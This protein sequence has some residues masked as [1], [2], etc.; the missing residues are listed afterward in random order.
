MSN[1]I[2]TREQHD[3]VKASDNRHVMNTVEAS[4]LMIPR[5]LLMQAISDL[6]QKEDAKAGDL[7][8]SLEDTV[9][10]S[11]EEKPFEFIVL[12]YFKRYMRSKLV[13]G[14]WEF[15]ASE[16]WNAHHKQLCN[17]FE[18]E[19]NGILY[20]HSLT[21]NF[22]V[23]SAD[24]VSEGDAFPMVIS[25]K[26][27]S[28]KAGRKLNTLLSKQEMLGVN[29]FD[30]TF[31]LVAKKEDGE[32][33]PYW[34]LDVKKGRKCEDFESETASKWYVM[35]KNSKPQVHEPAEAEVDL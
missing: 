13:N 3:V 9:V 34:V 12:E 17:M 6:V 27:T 21:H 15:D 23:L 31:D 26:S 20:R 2:M 28:A 30:R 11:K 18:E 16:D 19:Q 1:E 22:Y 29:C 14:K 10:G 5:V 4:D 32:K 35:I 24:E 8:N 7:V 33:G 25:F